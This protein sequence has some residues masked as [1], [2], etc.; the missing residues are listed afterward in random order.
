LTIL[1]I[2]IGVA[3]VVIIVALGAGAQSLVLSQVNKLGSNLISIEPG[4]SNENGPPASV[5]GVQ[6]TTLITEDAEALADK[7]RFPHITAVSGYARGSAP[8]IW[9]D[10]SID[11]YYTGVRAN[12]TNIQNLELEG[13]RFFDT[14]EELGANVVVLGFDVKD[15]LFGEQDPIG[16]VIKI[17]NQPFQVIGYMK[18]QGVVAFQN[19]DD[20]VFIP[21]EIAQKQL[22]GIRHLQE[23]HAK[24][25]DAAYVKATIEDVKQLMRE[26]HRI[27]NP[28]DEDFTVRDLADAIK[29]LTTITDGLSLF[30]TAMAA[31]ALVVGGIGIMNIMLVTVTERTREIGLRKAVGATSRAIRNQFLLEASIVTILGGVIGIIVG[32]V[33]AYMI[34]LG[35]R[36]AGFDW[37]YV[38]SPISVVLALGVSALT[39][40]MFG[41]YPAV[42]AARLDPIVALRYE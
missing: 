31:I 20:Q 22:L 2:V 8:M 16:E 39:G 9:R 15:Q 18:K 29:L 35:A 41:L 25:D 27:K 10:Q 26:R 24:V 23:I 34:A 11:S 19:Q 37:A 3:G 32:A 7:S 28:D 4:K 14:R 12:Y 33:I 17:K 6:I 40:I 1:G 5:F 13:G 21:L 36:Y 38:I 42:K 30:L